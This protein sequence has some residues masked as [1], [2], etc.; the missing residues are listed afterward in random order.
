MNKKSISYPPEIIQKFQ[1][2]VEKAALPPIS[3]KEVDRTCQE[4][5]LKSIS[6]KLRKYK[7]PLSNLYK[8]VSDPIKDQ[9]YA[10]ARRKLAQIYFA[11][12]FESRP[13][14]QKSINDMK[15]LP[16]DIIVDFYG[17]IPAALQMHGLPVIQPET[18]EQPN[19]ISIFQKLSEM[20]RPVGYYF[21]SLL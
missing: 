12:H 21:R 6:K 5:G 16:A 2:I 14:T 18:Q 20:L 3:F 8:K 17:S 4:H 10:L 9:A 19:E 7:K 15:Y 11:G 1:E 13:M